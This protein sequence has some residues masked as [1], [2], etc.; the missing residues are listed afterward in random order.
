MKQQQYSPVPVEEQI[1][2]IYAATNG[3]MDEL[4][5]TEVKRFEQ[6]L[7]ETVKVSQPELIQKLQR[8]K[9]LTDEIVQMLNSLLTS[10]TER[11]AA[12]VAA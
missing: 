12:T 3:F 10:F 7:L 6:E 9:A 11:F 1:V 2:T 8:D 4:P 5:V